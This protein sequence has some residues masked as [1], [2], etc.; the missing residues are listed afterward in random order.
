MQYM[1]SEYRML[2]CLKVFAAAVTTTVEQIL[3]FFRQRFWSFPAKANLFVHAALFLFWVVALSLL[4]FR[5]NGMVLSHSCD[6]TIWR[7]EMGM[8]VCR[9]YKVVYSFS[10]VCVATALAGV[11]LDWYVLRDDAAGVYQP[12]EDQSTD[13]RKTMSANATPLIGAEKEQDNH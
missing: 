7:T 4:T 6:L 12:L 8:M 1:P 9:L 10:V 11:A 5:L 3:S 2:T 13:M